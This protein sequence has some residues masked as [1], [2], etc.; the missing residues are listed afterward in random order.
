[1]TL[2]RQLVQFRP[3]SSLYFL[4]K[5]RTRSSQT[6]G[7]EQNK[8]AVPSCVEQMGSGGVGGGGYRVSETKERR[9]KYV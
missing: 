3:Q 7:L 6:N 4:R 1:M 9:E 2:K 5:P 8:M